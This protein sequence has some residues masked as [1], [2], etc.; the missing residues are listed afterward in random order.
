MK[1]NRGK[2]ADGLTPSETPKQKI[3]MNN[4]IVKIGVG[5]SS[6]AGCRL[7]VEEARSKARLKLQ[8][9]V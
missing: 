3:F 7:F 4:I 9:E 6:F 1:W 5:V 2:W 8:D